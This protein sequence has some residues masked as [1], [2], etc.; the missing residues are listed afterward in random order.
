MLT[1]QAWTQLF[2]L[3][4][5][6]M[7]VPDFR[8]N[9]SFPLFR[10]VNY[11]FGRMK[12]LVGKPIGKSGVARNLVPHFPSTF[13]HLFPPLSTFFH[14]SFVS[15]AQLLISGLDWLSHR[16]LFS[17]TGISSFWWSGKF[18]HFLLI[19]SSFESWSGV[20]FAH[21]AISSVIHARR[22]FSV[23]SDKCS[24]RVQIPSWA[25]FSYLSNSISL[26]PLISFER[27]G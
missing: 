25:G 20:G 5:I 21:S 2:F 6:A 3:N 27:N 17:C 18:F 22:G 19:E 10:I 16:G 23:A 13:Y 12:R 4:G 11:I 26:L 9:I 1:E 8:S 7:A 24:L 15:A 14:K